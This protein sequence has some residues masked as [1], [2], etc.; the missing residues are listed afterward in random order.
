L[1]DTLPED[2]T[3]V[4]G[5]QSGDT[6]TFTADTNT[7]KSD[8]Q[9]FLRT[10]PD[11][12]TCSI[13]TIA[14]YQDG[15]NVYLM[16]RGTMGTENLKTSIELQQTG[17]GCL[18]ISTGFTTVCTTTACSDEANGCVP[19]FTKCTKC[20]NNGKCTKTIT[21]GNLIFPSIPAGSFP[22]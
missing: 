12:E 18:F 1:T 13:T 8:W 6:V 20:A 9:S 14:F 17:G 7:L 22:S 2:T 15:S 4:I 11:F 10:I 19:Q 3:I 21:S 16:A 5:H